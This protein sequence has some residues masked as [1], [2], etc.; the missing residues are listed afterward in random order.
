MFLFGKKEEQF[1]NDARIEELEADVAKLKERLKESE[2]EL[3][4]VNNS[5]HLGIWKCFYDTAGNQ[6]GVEYSDEFRRMLGYNR[7]E[8]PD[9]IEALGGLIHPDEAADVFAAFGAAA[10]DK[11]GR[12]KFD[13]DYRLLTKSGEYKWYHAAGECIRFKGGKPK[14]FIGTFSDID[15]QV[16]NAA[17]LEHDTRRRRAVDKMMLEG[18]WSMDLTKYAIDDINSPMVFSHQF[19]RILGYEPHSAD[20]PDIMNSWIT[21]IHPDDVAAASEAMG[22]QLS[23]PSGNTVFDMEYRIRHKDNHYVWVRASSYVV[24]SPDRKPLMAA[25][26]IL[27]I[28]EQKEK[29]V[30]FKEQM[31]PN[32]ESLREGI[33][34]I[35]DNVERATSQMHDVSAR[36]EEV[37]EAANT[38]EGVVGASMH[39]IESI[40]SI[41][42]QTNL[43]SLNA[44]IEAARAG[45]AG[46]GF[47][48]VATEV[49][50]LATS[51]KDTTGNIAEQLGNIN[52][53]VKDILIKIN[54]IT[55]SIEKENDEM[56][57]INATIEEL[58]ASADEIAR[59][60][61]CLYK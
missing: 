1:E 2:D 21:K 51:T 56:S 42:T 39:I 4:A 32:I 53:S 35:A 59:M 6:T 50:S 36:Q 29:R 46:K 26:T 34:D 52:D 58:H 31:K 61:E 9:T 24:W 33:A 37:T 40:Q 22:R 54:Q 28:S 41:A 44:S 38:I 8:L 60:A 47:A 17:A 18:S 15:E 27:D 30:Q 16:K 45:E 5:T 48:V 55:E 11:S 3:D 20:F 57:T 25:G 43:L 49:Q 13:I 14:E 10:A 19:K 7:Q 12:T 23:D